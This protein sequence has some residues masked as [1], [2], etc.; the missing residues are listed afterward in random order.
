MRQRHVYPT[1]QVIHIWAHQSQDS[2]RN[3]S[4]VSFDGKLLYSY[5]TVIAQIETDTS[6]NTW[7]FLSSEGLTPRT[8]KHVSASRYA[9]RHIINRFYTPAFASWRSYRRTIAE[10]VQP[11]IDEAERDLKKAFGPRKR[12][13]TKLAAM[14]V[15]NARRD[16]IFKACQAFGLD[17]PNLPAVNVEEIEKYAEVVKAQEKAAQAQEKAAQA[18]RAEAARLQRIEDQEQYN[19]WLTTGAG[20]FPSSFRVYN[21]DQITIKGDVVITSQGAECPL[22]HAIKALRFWMSKKTPLYDDKQTIVFTPYHTNGHKIPLGHFTLD[23]IDS[24]GT[25]RAGCHTISRGEIERFISQWEV[26]GL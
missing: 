5:T 6:G 13:T 15:Y 4:N 11:A 14:Q 7:A 25:V 22:D 16:E 19:L 18:R 8:S 21:Q 26:L 1:A 23:S 17:A 2:A 20:R 10:M 12:Q 9:T 24:E 3:G